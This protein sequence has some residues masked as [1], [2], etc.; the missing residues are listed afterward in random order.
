MVAFQR[1]T[2]LPLD[3]CLYVLH[4]SITHLSRSALHHCLQRH[5]ISRLKDVRDDK[6]KRQK[7]KRYPMGFFY[8]DIAEVQTVEGKLYLFVGI[9]RTSKFG[10]TQ[11]VNK[12]D[13]RTAWE[14]LEHLLKAVL[15]RIHTSL[16]DNG[17]QFADQPRNRNQAQS[18]QMRFDMICEAHDS[19]H[20]LTKPTPLGPMDYPAIKPAPS[21][22]IK[23]P[24][25]YDNVGRSWHRMTFD[26]VTSAALQLW[27]VFTAPSGAVLKTT[28][29]YLWSA[30]STQRAGG[31][32]SV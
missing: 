30:M 11:L 17:I 32:R 2:L 24:L 22:K 7:F 19:E 31:K 14:F 18:R 16:T 15:Y 28:S 21:V 9:D 27:K 29:S 25:T 6:P 8:I 3:D 10:L 5:G 12:A 1:H 26:E 23:A 4:L 20:R 13:R